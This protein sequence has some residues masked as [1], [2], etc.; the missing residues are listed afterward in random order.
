MVALRQLFA[1]RKE[2]P[3]GTDLGAAAFFDPARHHAITASHQ[4]QRK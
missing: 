1:F 4:Q 3:P 2:L